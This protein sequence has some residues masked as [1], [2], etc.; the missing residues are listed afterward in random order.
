MKCP[1]CGNLVNNLPQHF[2]GQADGPGPCLE[3]PEFVI[4]DACNEV[5]FPRDEAQAPATQEP[6]AEENAPQEAPQAA[7]EPH[8]ED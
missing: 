1:Y 2:A 5:G 4:A 3:A 7:G 8:D 6:K